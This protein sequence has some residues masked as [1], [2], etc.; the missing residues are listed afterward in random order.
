MNKFFCN[1]K[2]EME[3]FI[4]VAL[5]ILFFVIALGAIYFA[6]KRIVG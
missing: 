6:I 4:K 1:K 3:N 2:S 5:W